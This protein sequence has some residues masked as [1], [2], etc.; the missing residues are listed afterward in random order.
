MA[1]G[2]SNNDNN[3]DNKNPEDFYPVGGRKV[4]FRERVFQA[5]GG[6]LRCAANGVLYLRYRRQTVFGGARYRF[7]RRKPG[8]KNRVREIRMNLNYKCVYYINLENLS[9]QCT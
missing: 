9:L 1:C 2:G 7:S 8:R 4:L 5:V 6:R 3:D